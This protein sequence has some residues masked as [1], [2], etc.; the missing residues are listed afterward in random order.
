MDIKRVAFSTIIES[1]AIHNNGGLRTISA[2]KHV[3]EQLNDNTTKLFVKFIMP[4][5]TKIR[6]VVLELL[7][8][9]RWMDRAI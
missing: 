9:Y 6:S 3:K 8:T 5:F 7:H 2:Q 4:N 1:A